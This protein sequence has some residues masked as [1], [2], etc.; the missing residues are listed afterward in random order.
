MSI[1]YDTV[2]WNIIEKF[3]YDNP[4]VL[5]KHHIDSY[6]DFF[7]TGLK[8][9]LKEKNPIIFQKEQNQETKEFNYRCELYLGGKDGSKIYYG[10]PII[11]D[12]D[13]EHYMYPNE[14]RLRNMTY[15]LAIHYDLE[16]DFKIIDEDGKVHES[17]ATYEK[18]FLGRFP[19]MLQSELCVLNGLGKE[20]RYNMGE[21]RNDYGGYFIIDGKEK[22][23]ISQEKFADN[24][25]YIRENYNEIYSHGADIRTVSEDAS[26][27][28][29]TLSVRIVAP[30]VSSP[31]RAGYSNNQIVVNIPNVRKPIPLFIVFRALGVI[32]DK[33]IIE[34]CLLDLEENSSMIDL[35]IPSIHD[36]GKIFTQETA[37]EYIKTFTKGH[38]TNYVLDILMNYFLPNI[39]E[40]NFQQ[41]AYFLGYI[42]KNLLLV[43]T[44]MELPTDRDSFKFKRVEVPGMLLYDLF[45]EYLKIQHDNIKLKFDKEYNLKKSKSVYQNESF[46]DLI[47]NN[48]ERILNERKL[49][50]GFNKAFKG[51]WGAQEHT[52]KV[53]VVQDLNRLSYNSFISHLRKINLPMDSSAKVVK[54]R[55]LHGSQ[56]GIIDPVDTPDGGNVGFH[57]HL[58]I[59]THITS[60]CSG[61]PIMKFMRSICKMKLL[62]ECN[63]KYLFSATKIMV[64]GAWIGVITNPQETIR[65]IKKYKRNGLLPI[66]NSISWNIKKN[67]LIIFTDSGRLCRPVFYIDEKNK[68]S[69]KRKEI[70]EKINNKTFTWLNLISGFAKKKD[71][72]YNTNTCKFYTIDE[73][74]DTNDFDKLESTEGIIDYLD[75]SEEETALISNNYEF[76]DKKPYTH[77]EIHPSLL[78]GV[79]GNQIVF[80]E[81][82]QL[83][84]DL[85][86]CGQA[87]QAAS[88]YS[89][90]VFS[91]IDKMGVV[92]NYGQIPLVK[93]RYLQFINNEQHPYG[94]NVIVAIMVYGGYNVEDSILFNEGSLKRGMFRTTY[95]NMYESR[96]ESSKVGENTIDSHFQNIEDTTVE[97]KKYGYDYSVLDKYGLVKENTEMDDEK[98]VIGK[99]QTN[100]VD[101]N[102]G[103]DASVYPKKGQLGFVDKTFMTEDEEGF[104]LAKVR[105][106][107]ERIPTIGDKFCS[108]C[109]QKGT[110]GLVIPEENMPF[111]EDGVRPDII[112]NPHAL[113]SRMTIGQLVETLMG[114]ACV[115]VGG[116][117][118][119]TAFIN[120][121]SKHEL[122]GKILTQSGYNSSGNQ[123]L[124]NGM[125]GEQLDAQIFIG[126]TYYMRLKHMVKD[127]INYRARGPKTLLTKQTVGGRANDGGLRIG[128]MERDGVI[129]HGAAGFLQESMLTRGDEYYL[130]VCNNTGTIAIYNTNQNLFLSP[131]AD[132]PIKF[133]ESLGGTEYCKK[134]KIENVSKYGRQFSILRIPYALK[135][136]IQEL[137]VMNIQLRIITEDN[138]EQLTNLNYSTNLLKL[139]YNEPQT[140]NEESFSISIQKEIDERTKKVNNTFAKTMIDREEDLNEPFETPK[141][142]ITIEPEAYG[143]SYYSYDQER[144]EVYKSLIINNKGKE[145]E[146]WFVGENDGELPNRYPVGW[147]VKTLVYNDNTPIVPNIMIEELNSNQV[148]NNWNISLEEIRRTDKG[149]P[150]IHD[151]VAYVNNLSDSPP[152]APTSPAYAPNSPETPPGYSPKSPNDSPPYDPNAVSP[153]YAPNSPPYDPNAVSPPYAPNSPV[154]DPNAVSPPYAPNSPVYDP[155]AVSPHYASDSSSSTPPPPP[156]LYASDSSSSTPSTPHQAMSGGKLIV[157]DGDKPV[158][159][160]PNNNT[161]IETTNSQLNE[162]E[163]DT[164]NDSEIE[165]IEQMIEKTKPKREDGI[166]LIIN[167]NT[168]EEEKEKKEENNEGEKKIINL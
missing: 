149:H 129:A 159:I 6:N 5:V 74:Y 137:Q 144:G 114:K 130:A 22:V 68:Q 13:R 48:Y 101:P 89:S 111:T 36:A 54:P 135:L 158:V 64:N 165:N 35:F 10:K 19:I 78:L 138:V 60:G 14:A 132:G 42:V 41:K 96:E 59:S 94:E 73:L 56:W 65:L 92:L 72:Y 116:Y 136:F 90:N 26:K 162:I 143:W 119:C 146:I 133:H 31:L 15:G 118:D 131:M 81:N 115:N 117:G 93:S 8:S 83:P 47:M 11:Y 160:M 33:K 7:R 121:G 110:V 51:N 87:K 30:T 155:N 17:N 44:K 142:N 99:I 97:G 86:F 103:I 12:E 40:L 126:P 79:M 148:P 107:E 23:I 66:Y 84:R 95:Y 151:P 77:I 4:Q 106:R 134:L 27:P 109:G 37:L 39:G 50:K 150:K 80:P 140:E 1:K 63:N 21:C 127:K 163:I 28:E 52:K 104:R 46:K 123:V 45:K 18:I 128:E 120:K 105:I 3:F 147:N 25:L 55:L 76:D 88:L 98:V 113:P 38:T 168:E 61:I 102:I 167:D 71:E 154:Y 91:R 34:Y 58:A 16:V 125:T 122:F 67:E 53:G 62:E 69:F 164:N 161:P 85:F 108:R 82:N 152:Y 112:I 166:E 9:V 24:M 145:S 157:L 153:P 156:P 49:E 20:V 100:L 124:Y 43:F 32:S 141:E 139:K 75:T 29:R 70:W 57:K 2:T